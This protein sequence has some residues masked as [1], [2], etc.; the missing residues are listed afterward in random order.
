MKKIFIGLITILIVL[1]VFYFTRNIIV[2]AALPATVKAIT[3][4][5]LSVESI[6]IGV[7]NTSIEIKGI[8]LLNPQGFEDRAMLNMPVVYVDYDL[9]SFFKGKIHLKSLKLNLKEFLVVKNQRGELNLYALRALPLKKGEKKLEKM[10]EI[11]IDD[12]ELKIEKV[13]YKDYL[14]GM[15]PEIREFKVNINERYKN[16]TSPGALISLIVAKALKNT[17]IASLANFD[18]RPLERGISDIFRVT[19]EVAGDVAEETLETVGDISKKAV[20]IATGLVNQT[21]GEIK[22]IFKSQ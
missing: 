21:V 13:I 19:G 11:K 8:K 22:G 12:L 14:R 1:S 10:P 3:G 6:D 16:V 17:T 20:S 18:L 2:K 5:G 4:L 7:F 9:D 15:P